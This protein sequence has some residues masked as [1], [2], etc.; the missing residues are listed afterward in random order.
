MLV[1]WAQ[2]KHADKKRRQRVHDIFHAAFTQLENNAP[3]VGILCDKSYVFR[4]EM[5]SLAK[6]NYLGIDRMLSEAATYWKES[7]NDEF[8]PAEM[9]KAF[10]MFGCFLCDQSQEHGDTTV[11]EL[12]ISFNSFA[13]D[14]KHLHF[15]GGGKADPTDAKP[16]PPPIY[17][18]HRRNKK[19]RDYDNYVEK[20]RQELG[21]SG[22]AAVNQA[23]A[24]VSGQGGLGKTAMAVEYA[25]KYAD[26]YSGGVFWVQ[27]DMGLG[28]AL[29]EIAKGLH[30][31]LPEDINDQQIIEIVLSR[32]HTPG[33][34][35]I[36]LDNQEEKI[37]P[38]GISN[39]S[40]SHL[41]VTTRLSDV[42]VYGQ[43]GMDIPDEEEALDI[44]LGYAKQKIDGL[45]EEQKE[46]ANAI[47]SRVEYLPLA[48]EI[49]GKNARTTPLA[50]LAE[51]LDDAVGKK[52][53]VGT[54]G[55]EL[56]IAAALAV[57]S[58]KYSHPQAK[59][60]LLHL[61]YLYP[62]ELD[63]E[64]LALVMEVEANEAQK[65]L[66]SLAEF[67]VVRPKP[68]VGYT[69][70][71][72]VQEAVRLDDKEQEV[73]EQVVD[74]LDEIISNISDKGSYQAGYPHIPHLLHIAEF[75]HNESSSERFPS[76]SALSHWASFLDDSGRLE[77]AENFQQKVVTRIRTAKGNN[78]PAY[79]ASLNNLS[80][81]F[82]SQGKYFEAELLF[83]RCL[84]I[85]KKAA[86]EE[87]QEYAS[88]LSNL[89]L[90]LIAQGKYHEA[91]KLYRQVTQ[92]DEKTI[93][94]RH[95]ESATG[96]N[97]LAGVLQAQDKYHE[98]EE[99]YR[100]TIEIIGSD[101]P[102][103]ASALNN[104]AG[105]LYDQ[106]K[107]SGAEELC[108]NA[109]GIDEETIGNKHPSYAIDLNNLSSVLRKQGRLDDAVEPLRQAVDICLR[110]LG[111]EHPQTLGFQKNLEILLAEMKSRS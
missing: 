54:K 110:T 52:S 14:A 39:L 18:P 29:A 36:V 43:I 100:Q 91:E 13:Q 16:S 60:A 84:K 82:Y 76:T 45:N 101:S 74:V 44:F 9:N 105:V 17:I 51:A 108:R 10:Y 86:G 58:H 61:S 28:Q 97:N 73:G 6:G 83:R 90:A 5:F 48:L 71:R 104:L 78:H 8:A 87:N 94:K 3:Q 55:K 103:Y 26:Q 109:I 12:A 37:V 1:S 25:R 11:G 98:A 20:I 95:P 79:A 57:T 46:A 24:A 72:L 92:I 111:P 85:D 41:L 93:G 32:M 107:F 42:N 59:E 15:G 35:L 75:S 27:A 80:L 30:W 19:L 4:N 88:H 77:P 64:I 63:K 34:K 49:L 22:Q 70:H 106:G 33:L 23:D 81:I 67:S 21:E 89:A 62:E 65:M 69:M 68:G 2:K 99:L 38:E 66:A 50:E 96:L 40:P 47:C 31:E 56:T 102:N 53:T 7:G